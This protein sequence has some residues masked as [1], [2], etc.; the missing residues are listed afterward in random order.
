MLELENKA[1]Y[2]AQARQL[3][4]QLALHAGAL[5]TIWADLFAQLR[6][7]IANDEFASLIDVTTQYCAGEISAE[8]FILWF[9]HAIQQAP[10]KQQTSR[11]LINIAQ[12]IQRG[13]MVL[14]LGS[15]IAKH[16]HCDC[17]NEQQIA[18]QLAQQED[19]TSF[20]GSLTAI[21][22]YYQAQAGI[23]ANTLLERLQHHLPKRPH[24][25]NFY[26]HLAQTQVAQVII[27][28]VYDDLLEQT[29]LA[30]NKPFVKLNSF[31]NKSDYYKIGYVKVHYSDQPDKDQII[32]AEALSKF[33][34]IE[35]GYSI[36]YKMRGTCDKEN[37]EE[38][39]AL[40]LSERQFFD[41]ARHGRGMIPSNL[42]QEIRKRGFL[43]LGYRPRSWDDRL[44][45]EILLSKRQN[46][47]E[48][49]HLLTTT[50]EPLEDAHWKRHKVE[51][52]PFDL[53]DLD[54]CFAGEN[55]E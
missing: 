24:A 10:Q 54:A 12:R 11:D 55:D 48:P 21:A 46:A 19:Y 32:T 34:F 30:A 13:D 52:Y 26:Q 49:C 18:Q 23:G 28:T 44:L 45:V 25:I 51:R 5:A 33:K 27:T 43:F 40:I 47:D 17:L 39:D 29:F 15:D 4:S 8:N 22:E 50:S 6:T 2:H 37:I 9:N 41:F 20:T 36:I 42:T 31:I 16:Y 1:R 3:M 7:P 14:F 35:Q 38:R 53:S